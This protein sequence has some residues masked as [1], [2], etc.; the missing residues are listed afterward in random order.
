MVDHLHLEILT[1]Y[2]FRKQSGQS[3][4]EHSYKADSDLSPEGWDYAEK[5]A[6]FVLDRRTKNLEARGFDP[7]ERKLVVCARGFIMVTTRTD[8]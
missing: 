8:E 6:E 1:H 3:L 7:T 2:P 5:L 4:L